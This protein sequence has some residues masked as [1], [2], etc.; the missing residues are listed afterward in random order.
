MCSNLRDQQL[1]TITYIC[2]LLYINL[3]VTTN[4]KRIIDTHTQKRMECKNNSKNNHQITREE[5]KRRKRRQS[6]HVCKSDGT[7]DRNRIEIVLIGSYII[8]FHNF[9]IWYFMYIVCM[10]TPLIKLFD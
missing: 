5:S 3:M 4:Q 2:R 7:I 10:V 1:K 8:V 9:E 6:L